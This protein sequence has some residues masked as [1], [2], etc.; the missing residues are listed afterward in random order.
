MRFGRSSECEHELNDEYA[1]REHCILHVEGGQHVLIDNGS[2]NG[3][4][5]NDQ[6]VQ[7]HALRP[8]DQIRIGYHIFKYLKSNHIEAMYHEAVFQMMTVD[9]LTQTYNRRYFEDAFQREV[10]RAGRHGR[11]LGLILIDV[12]HFKQVNDVYGHLAGDEVLSGLCRR[13]KVRVRGDEILARFGGEEFALVAVEI[14][15]PQLLRMAEEIR[16]LIAAKPIETT[17]GPIPVT[18]SIGLSHTAGRELISPKE[19]LEHADQKLYDA[20]N[21]GRNCIRF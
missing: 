4:F 2:L 17:K 9:A 8:G 3:T 13:I 19:M 21:S 5:V 10:L 18:V 14:S 20:K 1:S 16:D 7:R 6:L 12:D 11:E 15:L